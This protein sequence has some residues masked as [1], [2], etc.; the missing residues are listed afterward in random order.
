MILPW[1]AVCLL[2]Y[3]AIKKLSYSAQRNRTI[4]CAGYSTDKE[5]VACSVLKKPLNVRIMEELGQLEQG[6]GGVQGA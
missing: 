6:L 5:M 4:G 1:R 3:L 2:Q